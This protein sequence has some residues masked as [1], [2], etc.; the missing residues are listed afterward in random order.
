MT[1]SIIPADAPGQD[2]LARA[3]RRAGLAADDFLLIA[4][5]TALQPRGPRT[6]ARLFE[7]AAQIAREQDDVSRAAA[8]GQRA[9][10][11]W[12][13][14]GDLREARRAACIAMDAVARV[15]SVEA[16]LTHKLNLGIGLLDAGAAQEA[17]VLL[18]EVIAQARARRCL[19]ERDRLLA[20]ALVNRAVVAVDG[21]GEGPVAELLE[22]AEQL[23][24]RLQDE[25]RL[26]TV[27]INRATWLSSRHDLAGAREAYAEAARAY[28]AGGAGPEDVAAAVRGEAATLAAAGRYAEALERYGRA[29]ELYSDAGR[30]D[31]V[32]LTAVGSVMA[33]HSLGEEVP[34]AELEEMERWLIGMPPLEAG[35]LAMNLANIAQSQHAFEREAR[36]RRRAKR[37]FLAAGARVEAARVD[38]GRAVAL[39]RDGRLEQ[40]RRVIR[41]ARKVLQDAERW[42]Y[43]AHADHNLALVLEGM[44]GESHPPSERLL[45]LAA[46]ASLRSLAALDRYRHS[47]P[48]AA[49]RRAVATGT[50]PEMFALALRLNLLASRPDAVAAVVERARVQPVLTAARD[51]ARLVDPAPVAARPGAPAVAGRGRRIIL[52]EEARRVSGSGARW[53]GWWTDGRGLVRVTTRARDVAT[54]AGLVDDAALRRVAAATALVQ[55]ADRHAAAGDPRLA[56]RFAL[57]RAARGPLLDDPALAERVERDLPVEAVE[58]LRRDPTLSEVVSMTSEQLLWPLSR[59][60][61]GD[62]LLEHLASLTDADPRVKLAIAPPAAFGRV[63]WA[64]LPLRDPALDGPALHLVA[65]A[66]LTVAVPAAMSRAVRAHATVAA[67]D[68]L[69]II[70]DPH[71]DLPFARGLSRRGATLL[72]GSV[73]AQ[74]AT[75]LSALASRPSVVAFATHIRPGRVDDPAASALALADDEGR[76]TWLSV[77][78]LATVTAPPTCLLLG[79]DGAGAATGAEWTGVATGLLWAGASSVVT[80][81]LPVVEDRVAPGVDGALLEN[82]MASGAAEGLWRWQRHSAAS[83][84]EGVDGAHPPYRWGGYVVVA[85]AR[86]ADGLRG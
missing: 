17:V 71:D 26:G 68:D 43:V 78:E 36:L 27:L 35:K 83:C 12:G 82:V 25:V 52:S 79:C 84:A 85:T 63:P 34:V 2:A 56:T 57:W 73:G 3:L 54:A 55:I 4:L 20:A 42:L 31:E 22:E 7:Q 11:A 45:G 53:L 59:M 81:V 49:D 5:G 6:A 76:R 13:R 29:S 67:N 44:A 30:R 69:V 51:P 75:V 32:R 19:H 72:V 8:A 21:R 65:R 14:A 37:D 33:R 47:M 60:L 66:D 80:S 18:D 74:R 23:T 9:V 41:Q 70:A 50:Y 48:S 10:A 39:R 86:R 77:A 24:R 15:A 1:E 28:E 62:G 61:L 64:A 40:A 16:E 46:D 58:Q 38:L